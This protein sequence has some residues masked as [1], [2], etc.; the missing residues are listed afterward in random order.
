MREARFNLMYPTIL[1]ARRRKVLSTNSTVKRLR[2]QVRMQVRMIVLERVKE[3][4]R[5][6]PSLESPRL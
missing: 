6:S 2:M 1:P 4:G 3:R 5:N